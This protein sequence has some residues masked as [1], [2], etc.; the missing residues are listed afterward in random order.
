MGERQRMREEG[1]EKGEKKGGREEGTGSF[2]L[3]TYQVQLE[4]S[5]WESN[6]GKCFFIIVLLPSWHR[7]TSALVRTDYRKELVEIILFL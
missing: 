6:T 7:Q 5:L 1:R 2:R 4:C 3:K